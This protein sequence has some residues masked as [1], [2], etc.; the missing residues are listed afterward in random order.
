MG[1]PRSIIDL[2][3]KLPHLNVDKKEC[4]QKKDM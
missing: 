1:L 3:A 2:K 4:A